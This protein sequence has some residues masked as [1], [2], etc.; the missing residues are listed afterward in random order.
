MKGSRLHMNQ[1]FGK[2]SVICDYVQQWAIDAEASNEEKKI[3]R[4][5]PYGYQH[6]ISDLGD[7]FLSRCLDAEGLAYP[8]NR[9]EYHRRSDEE[10][11]KGL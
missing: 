10:Y 3:H 7:C 1:K 8:S 11:N 2:P 4:A 6:K 9:E 5:M